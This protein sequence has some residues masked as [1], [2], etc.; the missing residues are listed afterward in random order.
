MALPGIGSVVIYYA[1]VSG[2]TI[3]APAFV[4]VTPDAH[5]ANP[6]L[7]AQWP[8]MP[9]A[10]Q[11]G[12]SYLAGGWAYAVASEGT[13]AGDFSRISLDLDLGSIDLS[14]QVA[15]NVSVPDV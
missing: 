15:T 14:S 12:L 2:E 7:A 8:T 4:V 6:G 9:G 5:T 1:T 13:S 10:G 11:V 3:P